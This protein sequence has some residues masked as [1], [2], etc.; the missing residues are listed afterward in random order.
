LL[1]SFPIVKENK[2]GARLIH[3]LGAWKLVSLVFSGSKLCRDYLY[4]KL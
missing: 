1:V 4:S 2:D 3:V